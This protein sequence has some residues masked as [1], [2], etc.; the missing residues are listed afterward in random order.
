MKKIFVVA[1]VAG[2]LYGAFKLGCLVGGVMALKAMV[3]VFDE[4]V[5]GVKKVVVERVTSNIVTKVFDE[6]EE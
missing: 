4:D 6:R 5:P 3:D 2:G 1:G